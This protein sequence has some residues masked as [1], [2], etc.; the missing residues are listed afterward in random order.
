MAPSAIDETVSRRDVWK[1]LPTPTLHP[2]KE[3]KF[4][5]YIPP[6]TDGYQR[7]LSGPKGGSAIVIDNGKGATS[8]LLDTR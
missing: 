7:A 6:Q 3:A 2:V 8:Q 4:E 1:T 5:Q